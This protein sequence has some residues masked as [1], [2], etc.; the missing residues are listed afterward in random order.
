MR[1][2]T[3]NI[4]IVEEPTEQLGE[5]ANVSISF[6][7]KSDFDPHPIDSGLGGVELRERLLATPTEMDYD[8]LDG[9]PTQWP[10]RFDLTHWGFLAAYEHQQRVGGAAI[11]YRT[12]ELNMLEGRS[13]LAV[14]WDIFNKKQRK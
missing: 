6:L 3:N 2:R 10:E 11:A 9:G 13:D 4:A 14:L 1:G 5:Y 7:I 12:K 8:Q